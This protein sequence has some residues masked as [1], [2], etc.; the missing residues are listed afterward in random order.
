MRQRDTELREHVRDEARAVEAGLRARA[1]P[2]VRD[3]E[4]L[5]REGDDR[6]ATGVRRQIVAAQKRGGGG[7]EVGRRALLSRVRRLSRGARSRG[8]GRVLLLLLGVPLL[9]TRLRDGL[10]GCGEGDRDRGAGGQ[11]VVSLEEPENERRRHPSNRRAE[12]ELSPA[13]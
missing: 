3:A 2:G 10:R 7:G 11:R 4:V 1:A 12:R 13:V 5:H 6:V 8:A 9:L